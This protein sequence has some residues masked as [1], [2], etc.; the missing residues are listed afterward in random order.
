M[1]FIIVR[2]LIVEIFIGKKKKKLDS[3]LKL[4]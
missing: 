2:Y 1:W 4:D 3:T